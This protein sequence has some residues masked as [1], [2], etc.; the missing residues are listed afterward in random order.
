MLWR[1]CICTIVGL[2][3]VIGVSTEMPV[4]VAEVE[5]SHLQKLRGGNNCDEVCRHDVD[6]CVGCSADCTGQ[7][8]G[9]GCG[10]TDPDE[11]GWRCV[12]Y[13]GGTG[14][15]LGGTTSVHGKQCRCLNEECTKKSETGGCGNAVAWCD[16]PGT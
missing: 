1:L 8:D 16:I 11:R 13:E 15:D 7:D 9:T 10:E 6:P 4:P 5:A 3:C 14:C 12:D 2:A